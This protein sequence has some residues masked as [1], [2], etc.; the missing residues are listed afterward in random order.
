MARKDG[1]AERF[2]EV[3][4]RVG[5]LDGFAHCGADEGWFVNGGFVVETQTSFGGR[6]TGIL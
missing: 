5:F 3:G 1:P 6:S 4:D 2:P